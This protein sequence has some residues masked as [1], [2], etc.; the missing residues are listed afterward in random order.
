MERF[1]THL[2][3]PDRR[4]V[5]KSLG[6]AGLAAAASSVLPSRAAAA[7]VPASDGA[8]LDWSRVTRVSR[9]TPSLQVVVNP[10]IRPGSPIHDNVFSELRALHADYVRFVPWYPYPRLGVAELDPPADGR[11][12]WDFSL[13]DPLVEDFMTATRGHSTIMN[14]S[15]IPQWMWQSPW[16]IQD[17]QLYAKGGNNGVAKAGATWTDY[18]F[19][20]D[21]TP[22]PS[23]THS[24]APYA[25][26]GLLFRM[27]PKTLSG[28]GFLLSNYPYSSPA[29]GGYVVY[30]TSS[31]GSGHA[32]HTTPLPFPI[33]GGQT[34][35]VTIAVTGDTFTISIDGTTVATAT[36]PTYPAGTVGFRENGAESGMFDNVRVTAPDGTVLLSDDFSGDLTQWAAPGLPPDDPDAVDFAYSGGTELVVPIETVADYYRRLVA[37][38]TQGG[39]TDELGVFHKS[40]HHY[41]FPYWEVLNEL[42]H[43]LSPQLYTELYDAIVTE[44]G[45]VSPQ[46]KFVG[47]AQ[48]TP[49]SA[50][51]FT[52]FLDP[53]NH[54]AGVPIDMISYHF[55]AHTTAADT[56]ATYGN[57]GFPR[58]DTFLSVVDQI[59]AARLQFAPHVRTTV[60]ETGTIMDTAST[61]LDP[62]PIP[63]AYWN[64]SGAIYAY[65][66]ARLALKGIDV[67]NESQLVGYPGQYPSVSMVDWNTGL[68]NA[69]YRVLQLLLE[70]M[71]PGSGLVPATGTPDGYYLLGLINADEDVR[72]VL[73]VNKT[74]D[75]IAVPIAGVRGA[76]ARVV[77]QASAGGSI[78]TDR[79][80]GDEFTL[81]GY[82]VAV[83]TLRD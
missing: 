33:V 80:A 15:T 42:E 28:S 35:H 25:Q 53:A 47:V 18:T 72:K 55:Y 3:G 9:T 81:G 56:P 51:Y 36:D 8:S 68:P 13:I 7:A 74:D 59:E 37:W 1:T 75:Q 45:K 76:R 54:A 40:G 52:Y 64:Y 39:F 82:G 70:E 66:F 49:G 22:L 78:R 10:L 67:V 41:D 77:D 12:S 83:V 27:D 38:Y 20:V 5:L 21:V 14:F 57:T 11:T 23:A 48:A 16:S 73:V 58:A 17:G 79:V 31:N 69:R 32:V 50:K 61:Q 60:D 4:T 26:A 62:A 34:Y 46:T 19:T 30:I 63:N 6:A 24:G 2:Q 71:P 65:V 44:I 43:G 29:T